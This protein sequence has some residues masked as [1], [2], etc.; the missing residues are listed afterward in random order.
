MALLSTLLSA[1]LY[2]P[3]LA[4]DGPRPVRAGSAWPS[5]LAGVSAVVSRVKRDFA[6]TSSGIF[7]PAPVA[8]QVRSRLGLEGRTRTLSGPSPALTRARVLERDSQIV[9]TG[10]MTELVLVLCGAVVKTVFKLWIRNDPIADSLTGDLTD[11]IKNR[12]SGALDQRKLRNR[13]TQ[14][15]EIVADQLLS[16]L[17][18]EFRGLDEGEK[19]AAIIAV[20]ETFNRAQLSGQVLVTEDLDPFFLERY[21]RR[22]RGAST[23]DLSEG[24]IGLY[25][26]VLAQCCAYIIELADKLP[27]FQTDAFGELLSRDRQILGRLEDVLDRLPVASGDRNDQT[28]I[29]VAYRQRVA[30]VLD[31][32][33]RQPY[34]GS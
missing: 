20:T 2:H 28:R 11:M 21:V 9:D 15:E 17:K 26:R 33:V 5:V 12:V 19:N 30:T 29:D 4:G 34:F 23:R 1:L 10:E 32:L 6:C 24:G 16:M 27:G 18:N 13:F 22:F 14:M 3:N 7:P 31:R 8:L 25:D